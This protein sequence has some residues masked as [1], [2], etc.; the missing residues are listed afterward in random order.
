MK[1]EYMALLQEYMTKGV[2]MIGG[3]REHFPTDVR[4]IY[5]SNNCTIIPDVCSEY[6][7]SFEMANKIIEEWGT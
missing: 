2:P 6:Q 7:W 1:P 5:C 3:Y 4:C